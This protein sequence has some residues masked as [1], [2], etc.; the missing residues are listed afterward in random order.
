MKKVCLCCLLAAM[1]LGLSAQELSTVFADHTLSLEASIG[2]LVGRSEEIV[3]RDKNTQDKLS[4]LLWDLKPLV[5]AGLDI[6]Y[7]WQKPER[8]WGIFA[9]SSFKFGFPG[10]TGIMEDRDWMPPNPPHVLTHYSVHNNHTDTAFLLDLDAGAAF[11]IFDR[12]TIKPFIS[13]NYMLF[14]WRG[15]GGSI[16][17][18]GR[19]A[20]FTQSIDVIAYR[21]AWH[22]LSP[23]LRL[24]GDFN[25]Y[26]IAELSFKIS[27]LVWCI[28]EDIHYATTEPNKNFY[29]E[30]DIGLFIEPGLV[31]SFTPTDLFFLSLS[32]FYRNVS[33]LRGDETLKQR[34]QPTKRFANAGGAGYS[35]FDI[36]LTAKF[37]VS[38]WWRGR[39]S[40][41]AVRKT[42]E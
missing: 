25:R 21:Q 17:H 31:F 7:L 19:H 12:F 13:Y 41:L 14:S 11:E 4:Q 40:K 34:G 32:V 22:I 3:Y 20:Y 10:E 1:G 18:P 38:D 9:L 30:L 16:L 33:F 39:S 23:G 28:A 37:N 2:L 8:T 5:Y 27:P 42:G 6:Q 36:A 35:V 15:V 29:D 24:Y 26:F